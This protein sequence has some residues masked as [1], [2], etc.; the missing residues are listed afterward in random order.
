[1]KHPQI[2]TKRT[3]STE[4]HLELELPTDLIWFEGHFPQHPV[5]PG[6][7]LVHWAV[8]F[9]RELTGLDDQFCGMER[10]KFQQLVQPNSRLHLNL[11]YNAQRHQLQ[12]RYHNTTGDI[13]SGR[14]TLLAAGQ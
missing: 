8:H 2:I 6:V 3:D 14:I 9:G 10:V 5:L 4:L 11:A 1:M 13:A 12:F 7:V